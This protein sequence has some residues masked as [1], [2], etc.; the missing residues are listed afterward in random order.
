MILAID[1]KHFLGAAR[2]AVLGLLALL[3]AA[4]L[5]DIRPANAE[6]AMWVVKDADTTVYLLGTVH[7]L[8]PGTEWR[9]DKITTALKSSDALWLEIAEGTKANLSQADLW[10]FGKDP[11]H[12]LSTKLTREEWHLLR[13]AAARVGIPL[14]EFESMRPWLAAMTLGSTPMRQAGYESAQGV[15]NQLLSDAKAVGKPVKGLETAQEQLSFLAGLPPQIELA[16][17]N[18]YLAT[19]PDSAVLIDKIS[20]AWLAGDVDGIAAFLQPDKMTEADHIFYRHLLTNRN[21]NWTNQVASLMQS[22]GTH[23]IAVGAAH[24]AG[25]DSLQSMLQKRGFTVARF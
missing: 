21:A 4:S 19:Q 23:F 12:P 7:L 25:R 22:G 24:L 14:V 17:L 9:S 15:D 20:A 5:A 13:Q 1:V 8:K 18:Q 6:P 2:R 10:K 3:P 16:M 11:A